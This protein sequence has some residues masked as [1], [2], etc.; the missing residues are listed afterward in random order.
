MTKAQMV[1]AARDMP[2]RMGDAEKL[3]AQQRTASGPAPGALESWCPPIRPAPPKR[4]RPLPPARAGC[5]TLMDGDR[6]AP[7]IAQCGSCQK[8]DTRLQ[9]SVDGR[10]WANY[11][12]DVE[13]A[14]SY[15]HIRCISTE[16]FYGIDRTTAP[17]EIFVHPKTYEAIKKELEKPAPIVPGM[18]CPRAYH[19]R[20]GGHSDW[21]K[22]N[23]APAEKM[24][25]LHCLGCGVGEGVTHRARCPV[26]ASRKAAQAK[27]E[28]TLTEKAA[29][30]PHP[31]GCDCSKC[32]VGRAAACCN[33][34][35][36]KTCAG[37]VCPFHAPKVAP[38]PLML[39]DEWDLLPDG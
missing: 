6:L 11:T 1:Q 31:S 24:P 12:G 3:R 19:G 27:P 33:I 4:V 18:C 38:P 23:V 37:E 22:A 5:G 15:Q 13:G 20:S 21:C 7:H 2:V 9:V 8:L 14:A 17:K 28:P 29:A 10:N 34:G 35:W 26:M 30:L 32:K 36:H 39:L 16:A 25:P